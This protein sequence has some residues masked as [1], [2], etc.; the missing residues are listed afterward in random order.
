MNNIVSI[1]PYRTE[2]LIQ[3]FEEKRVKYNQNLVDKSLSIEE[4]ETLT[5]ELKDLQERIEWMQSSVA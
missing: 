3:E 5:K 1:V 2:E 4:T